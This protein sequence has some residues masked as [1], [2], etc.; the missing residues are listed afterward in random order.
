MTL[1]KSHIT[2]VPQRGMHAASQ[3]P[4]S[5]KENTDDDVWYIETSCLAKDRNEILGETHHPFQ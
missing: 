5:F 3:M 1:Q 2:P 4:R